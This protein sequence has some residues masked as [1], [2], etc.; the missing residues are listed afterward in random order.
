MRQ[1]LK[2]KTARGSIGIG[3]VGDQIETAKFC[4]VHA[5]LAGCRI[6]QAFGHAKRDRVAHRAV[7]AHHILVLEHDTAVRAVVGKIVGPPGQVHDL[8]GLD[9]AAARIDRIGA[10]A[11]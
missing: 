10:N 8:V 6:D 4:R 9:P 3:V 1:L 7:L 11:G 2:S 5:Q